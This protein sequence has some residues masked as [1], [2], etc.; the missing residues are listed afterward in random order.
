MKLTALAA[1]L[2]LAD[3]ATFAA[4]RR[5]AMKA[6]PE[7]A[8]GTL[9]AVALWSGLA[10]SAVKG[11]RGRSRALATATLLANGAMLAVHVRR[12]VANPR[13]AVGT[14]LSVVALAGTFRKR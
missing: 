2:G 12:K 3:A 10:M 11:A 5:E 8:A 1:V 4:S 7:R 14:G 6:N 13:I 9:G